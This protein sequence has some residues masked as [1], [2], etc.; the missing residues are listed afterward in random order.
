M[1]SKRPRSGKEVL[2]RNAVPVLDVID[3]LIL[4]RDINTTL[5]QFPITEEEIWTCIEYWL[6][7]KNPSKKEKLEFTISYDDNGELCVSTESMTDWIYLTS[8][9]YGR[10]FSPN[11]RDLNFLYSVGLKNVMREILEDLKNNNTDFSSSALHEIVHESFVRSYGKLL[12]EDVYLLLDSLT[13]KSND[14][15]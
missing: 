10:M 4:K 1:I 12:P 8:L 14:N 5:N 11:V 7:K 3:S 2:E 6:D 15:T 9:T 13:E